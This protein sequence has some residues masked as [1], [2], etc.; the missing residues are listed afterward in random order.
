MRDAWVMAQA[1]LRTGMSE[2]E[3]LAFER[4]SPE[5]HE[6]IDG[7]LFAMSGGTGDHAAVAANLIGELRNALFG[8]GCRIHTSDMR[9]K[10]PGTS[11]YVY[12]DASAEN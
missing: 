1:V 3:Y 12:P 6:Y 4:T 7:E 11:R 9:I 2:A 10:I 5:K 8:R